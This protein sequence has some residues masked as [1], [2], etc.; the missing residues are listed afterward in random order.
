MIGAAE[1]TGSPLTDAIKECLYGPHSPKQSHTLGADT[2]A[3]SPKGKPKL[4]ADYSLGAD[5]GDEAEDPFGLLFVY[6]FF[7]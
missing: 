4:L 1:V 3:S 2:E 5:T 6:L 7:Q